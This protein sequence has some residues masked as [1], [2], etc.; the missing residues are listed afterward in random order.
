M[1]VSE[2]DIDE[3]FHVADVDNDGKIGYK[4]EYYFITRIS[5]PF[6]P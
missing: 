3:M 5:G 4:V 6:G 2:K 1:K